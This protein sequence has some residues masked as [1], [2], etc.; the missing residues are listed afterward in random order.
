MKAERPIRKLLQ[1]SKQEVAGLDKAALRGRGRWGEVAGYR[2]YFG[3]K[4][5]ELV[6]RLEVGGRG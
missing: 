2:I 5:M 6:N 3:K 1:K 4:P